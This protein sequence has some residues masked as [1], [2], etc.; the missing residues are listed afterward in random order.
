[1]K[2]TNYPNYKSLVEVWE[3]KDNAY[4]A[5]VNSG[6]NY[7]EYIKDAT[8]DIIKKYNIKFRNEILEENN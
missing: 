4:K 3:M 6:K 7:I 1:M 8:Q 2:K 5:F